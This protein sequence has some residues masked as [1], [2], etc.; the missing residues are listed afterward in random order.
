MTRLLISIF[1]LILFSPLHGAIQESTE[2]KQFECT[3]NCEK[4]FSEIKKFAANGSPEAQ[5]LLALFYK[6]GELSG[7]IDDDKAWK[8]MR[9]AR[10]QKYTPALYYISTWHRIGYHTEVDVA[11]ANKFLERSAAGD[12]VPAILDLAIVKIK[13][14]KDEEALPLLEKAAEKGNQKARHL[15]QSLTG[16]NQV[17]A[18]ISEP[19]VEKKSSENSNR[20]VDKDDEVITIYGN[21]ME[22]I[23]FFDLILDKIE[24]QRIYNRK[25]TTGSRLGDLKCGQPG[26][27]C[28]VITVDGLISGIKFN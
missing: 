10:N 6:S 24:D 15:L 19:K 18:Q 26:S 20:A 5:T 2:S 11:K 23:V 1:V 17:V 8:W 25:G 9:R 14:N 13:N 16:Q 4:R 12:Y 22:P 28:R 3:D 21:Q 7:I 27:G